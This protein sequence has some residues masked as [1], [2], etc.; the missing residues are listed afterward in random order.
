MFKKGTARKKKKSL[1]QFL[2][3][4]SYFTTYFATVK[5][6]IWCLAHAVT[7]KVSIIHTVKAISLWLPFIGALTVNYD[8][9]TPTSACVLIGFCVKS[10]L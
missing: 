6:V 1:Y 10:A 9:C 5:K 3:G 7:K 2:K 4:Q 8:Y